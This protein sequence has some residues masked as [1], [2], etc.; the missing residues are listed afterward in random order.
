[1][2]DSIKMF[3]ALLIWLTLCATQ[4]RRALF[5]HVSSQVCCRLSFCKLEREKIPRVYLS[6]TIIILIVSHINKSA[7]IQSIK[8]KKV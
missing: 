2:S 1:M 7:I 5:S 3:L 6:M 4:K 8:L